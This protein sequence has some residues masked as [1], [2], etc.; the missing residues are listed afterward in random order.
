M[1]ENYALKIAYD[2]TRYRGWQRLA[3]TEQTVQGKLETV[4]GRMTG[5]P[6]QLS[7]SGR[8][9]AGAHAAGQVASVQ[10]DTT[11]DCGEIMAYLNE[12]LP[13]DIGVLAVRHAPPRFHARYCASRKTYVYRVWNSPLPCVFERRWC[14]VLPEPL[15]EA[16]MARAAQTLLGT[17]D[18]RAFC[19]RHNPKKSS[20][21]TLFGCTLAR[22]GPELRFTLCGDGFLY[23]MVRILCGTLLEIGWGSRNAAELPALLQAAS[24]AQA[25][26]TAPP[27]GLCLMGVEYDEYPDLWNE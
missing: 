17:H 13:Q 2:G 21:R 1:M 20:V 25:G 19:T 4:L 7:G 3:D 23:N 15:D 18:F 10:L 12:Y 26:F 8:T 24:R 9:D 16:A 6:V 14:Y 5:R 11:L 27:Q 22:C